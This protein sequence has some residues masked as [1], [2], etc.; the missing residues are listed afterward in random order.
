MFKFHENAS[1]TFQDPLPDAVDVVVIGGGVIGIS[2]AW[3][4]NERGYSVLVCD[5]GRVAGEQSSRNW[6]W[7]RAMGRDADEVPIAMDAVN[8]WEG[9]QNNLGDGIGFRRTGISAL[10]KTEK[11][12][13]GY[14]SW[15]D[16]VAKKYNLDTRL[17]GGDEANQLIGA[18]PGTWLGGMYTSSD[19]RAEPFTAVP[20][21][22]K[23]LQE[24]G[25]L[26]R[27]SCA[28]RIIESE[29]GK[30][31]AV[32]TEHGRIKTQS[33]V[34]AAGAWSTLFLSNLGIR[35]PQLA[36]RGTV[37]RTAAVP[38][39]YEG[40]G[41]FDDVCIRRREDGGYTIA[42]GFCEH[43]VGANSFRF[44]FKFI[45]SMASASE[46]IV[47]LG[48][49]V[50]QQGFIQKRWGAHDVSP[51][52][53]RRVNNPKASKLA[54]RGFRKRLAKQ[55]PQ[56]ADIEFVETWAG[57]IDA[58]PDVVPVMDEVSDCPGLFLATGFSG[59]GFGIGPAAGKVMADLVTGEDT[60]YDLTRFRFSRFS[61]GS[62]M[63]PGPA[64]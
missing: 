42:S 35:L 18:P 12:M 51:F 31:N 5:K 13:A 28:V 17:M 45:P 7:V 3:Y 58:T 63:R 6:G 4:L 53:K 49:D 30:V 59:H 25:G 43:F 26:I 55:I 54:E 23:A 10:A 47:R 15:I 64:I 41:S 19:G 38:A 60:G 61:D 21:I 33:V 50:T 9:F 52:E 14:Q 56:L 22:A 62:K 39:F 46:M 8:A 44:L 1:I 11:E 57:M 37:A 34:C 36:V 16:E 40:A 24:R 48:A 20:T 2:T 29:A 32:V 27:E